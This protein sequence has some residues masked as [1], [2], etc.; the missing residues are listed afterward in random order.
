MAGERVLDGLKIYRKRYKKADKAGRSRLLDEFCKQ[1]GYHRKYAIA[2]LRKPADTLA[3]SSTPRRRG[4]TYSAA[5]VRVLAQ[6]WKAAGY[7]WSE[8]LK[9]MLPQWLPWAHEHIGGLTPEVEAQLRKM[10]PRQMDRRLRN[11]KRRLKG[12]IYGRTKPGTLL[13]HHIPIKT[14]HWDVNEPGYCEID[15]VSHSGP[16]ASGEFIYS[17]N[18]TDI[19]TGWGETR[20]IM[21][22][23]ETGVVDALDD[24]R[25]AAPF[26]LK[27]IDSDNGSEF[28]NYHLY[29]YCKKHRLQFTRSRAYKKNDNAHI[30][31]KNWTHVRKLLG[32]ERYD[33][34]AQLHAIDALYTGPWRAMMNL[35]QP[36]VKLKEKV[37]VGSKITRRYDPAQT[38]LDRLAAFYTKQPLPKALRALLDERKRTDPFRLSESIDKAL[39]VLTRSPAQN[40]KRYNTVLAY[41]FSSPRGGEYNPTRPQPPLHG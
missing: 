2:V 4:P 36:C 12:R 11:K 10:S 23:G 31:Q 39:G 7:P 25:R 14:D 17:L 38:P 28:I 19:H 32:W 21:G 5:T 41:K 40:R 22:K 29:R 33:T 27:A 1:T 18:L 24:I 6:I 13:K 15:L 34:P 16:S 30:E 20:A 26:P 37:R 8:R 3:P 9:A 35:Y